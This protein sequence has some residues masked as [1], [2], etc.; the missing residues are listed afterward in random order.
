MFSQ[1]KELSMKA[2]ARAVFLSKRGVKDESF[3]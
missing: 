3:V 1:N 2:W